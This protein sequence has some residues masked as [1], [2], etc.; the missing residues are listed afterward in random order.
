[1][2]R[3]VSAEP[4]AEQSSRGSTASARW[5]L[6]IAVV[7]ALLA[8]AGWWALRA[9]DTSDQAG[10]VLEHVHEHG[11]IHRDVKLENVL[12]DSAGRAK[13]CDFGDVP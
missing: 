8:A 6:T 1:M 12:I 7:A 13:L 11:F 10:G 3:T 2:P 4:Q 5:W 9:T